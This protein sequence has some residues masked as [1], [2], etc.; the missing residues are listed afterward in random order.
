M[1][2]LLLT[3]RAGVG[4]FQES[5]EVVDLPDEE[6]AH[7]IACGSAEAVDNN[8]AEASATADSVST[9]KQ[10]NRRR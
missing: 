3:D 6:A 5:G 10:R 8:Q 4:W 2:V 1:K 9:H 7:L